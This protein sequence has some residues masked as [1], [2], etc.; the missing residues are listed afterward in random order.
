MLSWW[1]LT[2][3]RKFSSEEEAG[4]GD[5]SGNTSDAELEAAAAVTKYVFTK[6]W[7]VFLP[8]CRP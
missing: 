3:K 1:A 6:L 8:C 2:R 5:S 4:G 7:F